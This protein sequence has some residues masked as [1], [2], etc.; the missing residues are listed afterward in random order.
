MFRIHV[1]C[2]SQYLSHRIQINKAA[3]KLYPRDLFLRVGIWE[4]Q[5]QNVTKVLIDQKEKKAPP[6]IFD[7][8]PF[9]LHYQ[10]LNFNYLP[11]NSNL[12]T[13]KK[14]L[15]SHDTNTKLTALNR[16]SNQVRKEAY[17]A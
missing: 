8:P 2:S 7:S 1:Q 17:L 14:E 10:F 9:R 12:E 3:I 13:S 4:K 11:V 15:C 16:Y 5:E 6:L